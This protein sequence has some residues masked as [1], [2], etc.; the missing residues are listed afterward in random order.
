M[1]KSFQTVDT[2]M[3][4]E[5]QKM[6]SVLFQVALIRKTKR[7]IYTV[8]FWNQDHKTTLHLYVLVI[9]MRWT[10]VTIGAQAS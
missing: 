9:I 4:Y 10:K 5:C 7:N 2:I 3:F 1:K 8:D 6:F